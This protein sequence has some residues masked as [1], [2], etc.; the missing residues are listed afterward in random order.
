MQLNVINVNVNVTPYI[1]MKLDI[2]MQSIIY[3]N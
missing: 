2:I 1:I 3:I